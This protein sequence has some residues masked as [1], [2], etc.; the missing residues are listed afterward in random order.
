VLCATSCYR[1]RPDEHA[2]RTPSTSSLATAH[3]HSLPRP[4]SSFLEARRY[5]SSS[6]CLTPPFHAS[7]EETEHARSSALPSSTSPS[8]ESTRLA[9]NCR[10]RP[11][12]PRSHLCSSPSIRCCPTSCA[13]AEAGIAFRV[14]RRIFTLVLPRS[15]ALLLRQRCPAG[16][17]CGAG[18]HG[19]PSTRPTWPGPCLINMV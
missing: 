15:R 1:P 9:R 19:W 4:L 10:Q 7:L 18:G 11:C 2:T 6:R 14:S 5:P 3:P 12:L 8:I 17:P 16:E 13:V